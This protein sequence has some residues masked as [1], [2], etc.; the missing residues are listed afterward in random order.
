MRWL[1]LLAAL[2]VSAAGAQTVNYPPPNTTGLASAAAVNAVAAQI[3]TN[4]NTTPS[5]DTLMGSSGSGNC[6]TP[7][8]AARP[9]AVQAVVVSTDAA[10]AWSVT[11]GKPFSGAQPY[12]NAQP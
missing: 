2:C 9:T 12:I 6:F 4:C 11:W 10:G 3:P 5:A 1:A 7:A 8:S